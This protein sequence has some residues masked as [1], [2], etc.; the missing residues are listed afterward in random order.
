[1]RILVVEDELRVA[2]AIKRSLETQKFAV[3]IV[4]DGDSG[5]T[6][7]MDPDYDVI[8]LD[9]MLPGSID[10]LQICEQLRRN[11]IETPVLMLTALGELDD[12]IMGLKKGADD[13]LVKPFSMQELIVRTQVLLRRPRSSHGSIIDIT[14]LRINVESFEIQRHNTPIQLSSREFKLLV[15]LVHSSGQTVS[16]EA[17]ISHVWDGNADIMINTVEVY[18]GYLRRKIDKAFPASPKLVHTI[19]GFGYKFGPM[20]V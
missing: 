16:K 8:I 4:G 9:R 3:D 1:M 11:K 14:D 19:H 12:R 7:A 17:I 6:H 13:Y 15:Y 20:N 2:N 10:G 18:V 5:L